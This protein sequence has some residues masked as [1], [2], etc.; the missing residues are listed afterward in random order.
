MLRR[1]ENESEDAFIYRVCDAKGTEDL[2][3]WEDIGDFLNDELGYNYSSSKYRKAY[4]YTQNMIEANKDKFYDVDSQIEELETLKEELKRERVKLQTVN[5]EKNRLDRQDARWELFYEQIGQYVKKVIPP[6]LE[7]VHIQKHDKKYIQ[8]LTDIHYGA[9]FAT[10]NNEYNPKI[11]KDRFEIL[12]EE[13]IQ[14]IK[15]K[16]ITELTVVGLQDFIQGKIHTTDLSVNDSSIVKAV[17]EISHIIA[18]YLND[19]SAYVEIKYY[20]CLYANHSQIRVLGTK[21]N[22]YMDE[23]LGFVIGNYIKDIL[24]NNTRVDIILAKEDDTFVEVTNI[25]NYNIICGHGHQVKGIEKAIADLS[26]QRR[27]FFDICILGHYH[28][29]KEIV[30]GESYGNDLE[31]LVANGF[32]GSDPYS[33]S[34]YKGAKSA[35]SIYGIDKE[36]GHTETYKIVLN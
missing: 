27:K 10:L 19:L 33:N 16:G 11:V 3:T 14:F 31:V 20:D 26:M 21:A 1:Y 13:T 4:Q 6:Q 29:A 8:V 23:D 24:S 5:I 28:A 9:V 12:K 30:V 32:V 18:Q 34:L 15:E 17:V 22:E 36:H 35:V 2:L 25:Y 7:T